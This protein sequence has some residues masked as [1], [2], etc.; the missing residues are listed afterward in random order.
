MARLSKQPWVSELKQLL[1]RHET[2]ALLNPDT[3]PIEN[4]PIE[5]A[6]NWTKEQKIK[7]KPAKNI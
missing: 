6:G 5:W 4:I 7:E 1:T 2:K 3:C